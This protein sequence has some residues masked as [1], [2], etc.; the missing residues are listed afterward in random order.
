VALLAEDATLA[1]PPRPTWYRGRD[2][3][4]TFLRAYPLVPENRSRLLPIGVNG[5]TG[6]GYYLWDA[7]TRTFLAHA[8]NVLTLRGDRITDLMWFLTPEAFARFDLPSELP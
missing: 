4:A 3:A 1:M 6:F 8:V 7:G 2:A 5:Q